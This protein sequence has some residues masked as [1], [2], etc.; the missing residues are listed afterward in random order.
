MP[1]P[2]F[3]EYLEKQRLKAQPVEPQPEP[4]L[5][6]GAG[7]LTQ[8]IL[9][10][11][12]EKW[13]SG[14]KAGVAATNPVAKTAPGTPQAPPVATG[15]QGGGYGQP[16]AKPNDFTNRGEPVSSRANLTSNQLPTK[17]QQMWGKAGAAVTNGQPASPA[18]ATPQ[19]QPLG[20]APLMST[21]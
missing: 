6:A 5:M 21:S 18:N 3:K 2:R 11:Q 14:E 17:R 16:L 7:N 8:E 1:H 15:N 4:P 19:S 12:K 20:A 13:K 9:K 10:R